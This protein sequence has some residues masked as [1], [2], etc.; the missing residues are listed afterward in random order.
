MSAQLRL[1]NES[2]VGIDFESYC[3]VPGT[4]GFDQSRADARKRIQN[5]LLRP[6]DVPGQSV[7]RKAL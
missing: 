2:R 5:Q 3:M 6:V 4:I 7:F 1:T